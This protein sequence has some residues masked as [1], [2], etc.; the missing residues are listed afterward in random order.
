MT[1][2]PEK[3]RAIQLIGHGGSEMLR[4]NR[5]MPTPTPSTDEVLIKTAAAGLNN[6]DINTR[7]GW[8]SKGDGDAEDASWGGQALEFPRVQGA[9]ICGTVVDVGAGA[10]GAFRL[11]GD[12]VVI[13]L[14]RD[15]HHIIAL[16]VKQRGGD[17]R[18]DTAGH[19]DDDPCLG[20]RLG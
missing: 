17:R 7:I 9:D 2:I 15:P 13:E 11:N 12:P 16:L 18:I 8:Y 14:E 4:L 6:T 20:W 5:E 1:S 19:G 3:M 10:A